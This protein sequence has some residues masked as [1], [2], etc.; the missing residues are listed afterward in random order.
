MHLERTISSKGQIVIPKDIRDKLGLRQGTEV[1]LNIENGKIVIEIK[2]KPED[3]VKDFSNVSK[4]IAN[5]NSKL[6]KKILD[7]QYDLH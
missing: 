3:I 6:I 4:K 2:K 1:E 5:L 7:E